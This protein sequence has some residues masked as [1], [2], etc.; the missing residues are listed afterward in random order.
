MCQGVTQWPEFIS[1]R[2]SLGRSALVAKYLPILKRTFS[3]TVQDGLNS[4]KPNIG[5]QKEHLDRLVAE[6]ADH[7]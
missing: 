4:L 1:N 7:V 6:K 3:G 2:H 5:R